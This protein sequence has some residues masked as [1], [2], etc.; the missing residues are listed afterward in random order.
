MDST[1]YLLYTL[2]LY[3]FTLLFNITDCADAGNSL[4]PAAANPAACDA[5]PPATNL[6]EEA[7]DSVAVAEV[8]VEEV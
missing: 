2:W 8:E 6:F 1:V 7:V 5:L 4:Y 3:D